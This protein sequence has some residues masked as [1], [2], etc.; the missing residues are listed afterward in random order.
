M[1][2]AKDF[3]NK[4]LVIIRN[5]DTNL[6]HDKLTFTFHKS[7]LSFSRTKRHTNIH[8]MYNFIIWTSVSHNGLFINTESHQYATNDWHTFQ[9]SES[10]FMAYKNIP[11]GIKSLQKIKSSLCSSMLCT[12]AIS[13]MFHLTIS[14]KM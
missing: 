8:E 7:L 9:S 11:R 3:Y 6:L 2:M 5:L 1:F 13:C 12:D 4:L 10:H 14:L